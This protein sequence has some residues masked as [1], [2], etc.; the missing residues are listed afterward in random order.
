MVLESEDGEAL[1]FGLPS[2]V[3]KMTAGEGKGGLTLRGIGGEVKGEKYSK[4][5]Y[6]WY[7]APTNP[8]GLTGS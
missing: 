4:V 7:I 6:D 1:A 3:E 5:R 2:E 8:K